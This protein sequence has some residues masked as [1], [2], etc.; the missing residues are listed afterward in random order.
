MR[1]REREKRWARYREHCGLAGQS[2]PMCVTTKRTTDKPALLFKGEGSRLSTA[3]APGIF[4][5]SVH[6]Y[7]PSREGLSKVT[8]VLWPLC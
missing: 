6:E 5:A 3:P 4:T 8:F 2:L 7:Q 1:K